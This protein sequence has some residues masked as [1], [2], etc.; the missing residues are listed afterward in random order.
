[1]S[2]TL[3]KATLKKNW[4]LFVIIYGV[5]TMY[6]TVMISMYDPVDITAITSMLEMFPEG[7]LNAMGFT[8]LTGNFTSYLASFLY[9]LLMI[10]FPM[11]YSI[12][13]SNKLVAKMVD[14]G[15]FAYLLSTPNSRTKIVVTQGIYA[16]S[17]MLVLFLAVTGLGVAVCNL[18]FPGKL[19][20]EA[21]FILNLTTMLVDMVALMISFFFSC[22]FN[23]TRLSIG[24]GAG[25]PIL[26]LL[27]NMIGGAAEKL[28]FLKDFTIYGLYDPVKV[29]EGSQVWKINLF[30]TGCILVL[31]VAGVLVFR[32]KRL[33]L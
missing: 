32:K 2:L 27:L 19:D 6:T 13:L 24:F 3:F 26:F 22:F 9:G 30:Y 5:L 23:E 4:L 11:I 28:N 12:I 33:P 20:L 16:L 18:A 1:M 29:V 21:Y 14:N 25:I 7:L 10:A 15:S 17:S 31:F 8:G